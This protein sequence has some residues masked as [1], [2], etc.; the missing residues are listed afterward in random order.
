[1]GRAIEDLSFL[2]SPTPA[3]TFT[4]LHMPGI[5]CCLKT[6]KTKGCVFGGRSC[7]PSTRGKIHYLA[8]FLFP[9]IQGLPVVPGLWLLSLLKHPSCVFMSLCLQY[10]LFLRP[11][12]KM[13]GHILSLHFKP[14]CRL[15]V[16]SLHFKP[17]CRLL[18]NLINKKKWKEK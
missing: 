10:S 13:R 1:M 17:D 8:L 16:N 3:H 4:S 14:G 18:V 15:L 2:F 12:I 7:L 11:Y 9:V 5:L 6:L